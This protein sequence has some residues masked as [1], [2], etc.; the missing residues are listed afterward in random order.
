[1]K[2]FVVAA[3]QG[4]PREKAIGSKEVGVT[5]EEPNVLDLD[6]YA[7]EELQN[8]FDNISG[9]RFNPEILVRQERPISIT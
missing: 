2:N 6:E 8:V 3:F 5:C 7:G 4:L 1:M 9:V